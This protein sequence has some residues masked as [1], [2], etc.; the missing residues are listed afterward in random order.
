MEE[1]NGTYD[2]VEITEGNIRNINSIFA[3]SINLGSQTK[4]YAVGCFD[5]EEGKETQV[6]LSKP[7]GSDTVSNDP[8]LSCRCAITQSIGPK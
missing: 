7:R 5:D 3:L 8:G 2:I 4:S 1:L 6:A